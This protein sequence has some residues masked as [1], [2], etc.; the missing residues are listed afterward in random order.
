MRLRLL[1]ICAL[2]FAFELAF[3]PR[4]GIMEDEA[5]FVAPFLRD[6]PALYSWR[7]GALQVPV[8]SMA[9]L[10]AFKSW[11]YWPVFH[12]WPP[13][14][15]S[16]RLPACILSLLT[17]VLFADLVRRV[18]DS[19]VAIAAALFLATDAVFVLIDVFDMTVCLLL[20]GTVAFLNLLHR[21]SF[22]AAFFVAGISL[23]YKANFIFPLSGIALG[24]VFAYP[25]TVKRFLSAR[26]LLLATVAF[27]IGATPLIEF[28]L[29]QPGAT[30]RASGDLPSVP[31][32]EKL[33][34]LRRTLDGRAFEHYMFRSASGEK[35]PLQG[36]ELGNLVLGWYRG[37]NFHPGSFLLPA[38]GL[39]LLALP[40]LGSS[41]L[42]R[43]LLFAWVAFSVTFGFMFVLRDAG[44]GPHHT[45]LL[46]PAPQFIV[47]ATGAALCRRLGGWRA[48]AFAALTVL[49]AGSG[50]WLLGQYHRAARENG[51][52]VFWTD[53]SARLADAVRSEGLPVAVLDWGIH[54]SLQI[55]TRDRIMIDEDTAPRENVLYVGHCAGYIIDDSRGKRFEEAMRTSQ[56]RLSSKREIPDREGQP[57]FCLFR[58]A[59][60]A[61][62]K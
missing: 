24:F 26:N 12:L 5:L 61:R 42:M 14:V 39:A 10:G 62:P 33:M 13:G 44:A 27:C 29:R 30:F 45:V 17:L 7:I 58:L 57:I 4:P 56:F 18:S 1:S 15:W 21:Q 53:G 34:M 41:P 23:W 8:M 55:E 22:A 60:D 16:M 31:P 50:V 54:N 32:A 11:L 47:A 19:D 35:I 51:F 25:G 52:S 9:Y 59:E 43:P 3:L 36:A 37:S 48:P 49:V 38:L 28:N 46:D 6:H 2:L 20:L 40:F